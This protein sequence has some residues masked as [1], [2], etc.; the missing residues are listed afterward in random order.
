MAGDYY[1]RPTYL[2]CHWSYE[3]DYSIFHCTPRGNF[4][5]FHSSIFSLTIQVKSQETLFRPTVRY[6]AQGGAL[7]P[8]HSDFMV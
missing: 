2:I 4:D 6:V 3:A 5:L 8:Y 7:S 1:P